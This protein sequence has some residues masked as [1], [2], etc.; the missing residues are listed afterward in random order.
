MIDIASA[1]VDSG[2]GGPGCADEGESNLFMSC[3]DSQF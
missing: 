3:H 1:K 2:A